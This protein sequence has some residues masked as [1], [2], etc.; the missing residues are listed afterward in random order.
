MFLS[1]HILADV[2][3]RQVVIASLRLDD[4]EIVL[5]PA[6]VNVGIAGILLFLSFVV[7]FQRSCRIALVPVSYTHLPDSLD[8]QAHYISH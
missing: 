7:G 4:V 2:Y 5:A 6:G 1:I 8:P 3:K